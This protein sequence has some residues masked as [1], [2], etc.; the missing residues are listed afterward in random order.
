[1][2][3]RAVSMT[4]MTWMQLWMAMTAMH[5]RRARLHC[6]ASPLPRRLQLLR[7]FR[8]QALLRMRLLLLRRCRLLPRLALAA[9]LRC[10]ARCCV[11]RWAVRRLVR[12][13]R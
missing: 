10:C 8:W 13:G 7:C 9:V 12:S 3:L 5:L 4:M 11:A 6:C 1:M 2:R